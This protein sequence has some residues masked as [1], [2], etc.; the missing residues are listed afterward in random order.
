MSVEYCSQF[1]LTIRNRVYVSSFRYGSVKCT[2]K[3]RH[4][5][6]HRNSLLTAENRAKNIH[7]VLS[8]QSICQM[9][10]HC[11]FVFVCLLFLSFMA[12]LNR[13]VSIGNASL[14]CAMRESYS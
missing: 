10:Q 12:N 3:N 13:F 5:H 7:S 4:F 14:L 11:V 1:S 9:I 6:S 2:A 8:H